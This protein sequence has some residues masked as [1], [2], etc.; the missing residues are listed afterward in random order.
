MGRL[1]T[2]AAGTALLALG[3]KAQFS[4]QGCVSLDTS[5]IKNTTELYPQGPVP[6]LSFCNGLGYSYAAITAQLASPSTN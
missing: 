3:V 2:L 4:Y 1:H 5:T 6:C